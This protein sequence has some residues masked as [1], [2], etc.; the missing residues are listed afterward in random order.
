M[1]DVQATARWANRM[2]RP[3]T[4]IYR[5][6]EKHQETL[7]IIA[8]ESRSQNYPEDSFVTAPATTTQ[9]R[10][11]RINGSD[12]DEDENDPVW[13][14][15]KK[16]E[17]R[18]IRHKYSSRGEENGG[19]RRNRLSIHSPEAP[20]TLPGAI[21]LATPLINGKRWEAPSSVQSQ[22][23]SI[24]PSRVYGKGHLQAFRDKYPLHKSPW[25]EL[26]H[27][28]GDS[29]FADIAHNLHRVLQNFLCNTRITK[30]DTNDPPPKPLR[31]A[32]SLM[33][34]VVRRLPEFI[35]NEQKEQGELDEDGDEDMCGAYFTELESFYAPHGRGWKP[36]REAV[37]SQGIH[38]VA[39]MIQNKWVTEA[40]AC[41]LIEKCRYH[42]PDAC[43][44]LL[45]T[46]LSTCKTYP[47]PLSLRPSGDSQLK[48][49]AVQLLRLYACYGP[50][51]RSY[52]FDELAKLLLRGV[53]PPEWMATKLWTSWMTRAT[54]SLSKEDADCAAASRLIEAV[55]LSASGVRPDTQS[56]AP[57]RRY[58]RKRPAFRGGR[59]RASSAAATNKP[60]ADRPCPVPVE[61]ALSNHVMS[62]MAALCGMHVSRSRELDAADS[63][64][65]TKAGVILK[66]VSF[67]VEREMDL[68][69]FSGSPS[70]TSHHLLRRGCILLANC[71][72]RCNTAVL[73]DD[74]PDEVTLTT[75]VDDY[76]HE[77]ASRSNLVKELASFVRQ[78]FRCFGGSSES[79]RVRTGQ[80]IRRM[81]ALFPRLTKAPGLSALLG[82]IAAEAAMEFAESTG[83]PEDHLWAVEIQEMVASVRAR[84][85][86]EENDGVVDAGQRTGLYRWEESIGEW[87]ARTPMAKRKPIFARHSSKCAF[88][89]S[90]PPP[91]IP[92]STDSSSP[93]SDRSERPGSSLTSSPSSVCTKRSLEH[94]DSSPTRPRKRQRSASVVVINN[95]ERPRTRSSTINYRT[96]SASVTSA[97]SRRYHL[98]EMSRT[99]IVQQRGPMGPRPAPKIEVV[100]IN[101]KGTRAAEDELAEPVR[102]PVVKQ[103]HHPADR[104]P[105]GRPP[106]RPPSA[107]S[108]PRR[109]PMVIPCSQDEDSDDELSFM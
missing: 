34:M 36:L 52:I 99:N 43:E 79:E 102:E 9:V 96:R 39:M 108:I 37:R 89:S 92:C 1:E 86:D 97:S 50:A 11:S 7:S 24:K 66:Y 53:L 80:E 31:G 6:L 73:S 56:A 72:L 78:A 29:G 42:E 83:E 8:T 84:A 77:L 16:V 3:L 19:R 58:S 90:T 10:K 104:R 67:S 35:A 65:G 26:L 51:H 17:Q 20:R 81:I 68:K 2:L 109:A 70:I 54:I 47:Y 76:S 87:V 105:R 38:L 33:S 12:A 22:P 69:P 75:N 41:A 18:R 62:L 101:K 46:F 48:G 13:V 94:S 14:P 5:R 106:G 55:I 44:S 71:L 61:D 28:S 25:Q 91:C 103:V 64:G 57:V 49:D 32:R 60:A 82:R 40:V 21:E 59:T 15:G 23:S 30:N 27:Q 85:E 93:F 98:R 4:S 45:S 63:A 100:I 95:V 107:P 74:L 88:M